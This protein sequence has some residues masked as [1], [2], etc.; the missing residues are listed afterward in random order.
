MTGWGQTGPLAK[1]PGHDINYIALS[2]A[3]HAIGRKDG[4][5][6]VPLNLIGD[7]GGGAMYLAFGVVSA[8]LEARLSGHGQVVDA[9][10]LDGATSLMTMVY[11]LHA[12]GTGVTL[13]AAIA[14]TAARPG[15]TFMR[16]RRSARGSWLQRGALLCHNAA[17]ARARPPHIARPARPRQLAE[18][19][20]VVCG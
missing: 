15:T 3:L 20:R 9:A 8:V 16:P 6:E 2:G 17:T 7:F 10:M 19:A 1:A 12:Q 4:P 5:P 14:S 11:G 13:V 18:G